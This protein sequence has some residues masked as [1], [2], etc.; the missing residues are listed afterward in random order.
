MAAIDPT[1]A[2]SVLQDQQGAAGKVFE[3]VNKDVAMMA[4]G[5]QF[6]P[7]EN[8][9]TAPMKMQFLQTIVQQNP[10]YVQALQGGD[11]RFKDLLESYAKNLKMSLDQ[12]A[13]VMIGKT[14]VKP[15]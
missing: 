1:L 7:V 8:D 6:Q 2:Q 15:V 5:N 4:L 14:G 13:N 10:K 12:Q 9:P 3:Q 11:E